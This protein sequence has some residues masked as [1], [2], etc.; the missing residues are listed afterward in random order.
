MRTLGL[1]E[2]TGVELEY[3]IVDQQ[4]LQVRPVADRLLRDVAGT[5]V[6]EVD[7]GDIAWSNE[8]V[9]H[10]IELKTNGPASDLNKLPGLFHEEV[11]EINRLLKK[12][13]AQLMPTAMHPWMDPY[14]EMKLWPHEYNPI[15]EAY[16]RIF[17]CRGHGWANL[18][19]T[20]INLPFAN[21]QEFEKLHAAIRI[22]L[23]ILPALAASS[24]VADNSVQQ[25][26]DYRLEVY[27]TN[28][29][30][31][32]SVTGYVI[33]EAVFS[34]GDYDAEILQRMYRDIAPH[35]PEGI[36]QEEWLNSRGAIARFDRGSIEI[37][38][39]DIQECPLA[40][41]GIVRIIVDALTALSRERWS[42]LEDQKSWNEKELYKILLGTVKHAENSVIDNSRFLN[43]FGLKDAKI[44]AGQLWKHIYEEL[45]G[46]S[47]QQEPA[48][49]MLGR[50]LEAGTLSKRI[51]AALANGGSPG[52]IEEIYRS[53]CDCLSTNSIFNAD[54]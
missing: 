6:S 21:D 36:L 3:M 34:R 38:V 26:A 25:F 52:N 27:R 45:Y 54:G 17:D 31:I 46:G 40:D 14:T 11:T 32:P 33:P 30:R 29:K 53:L 24:P 49:E 9:L 37:R 7:R 35:D 41:I 16:N 1:F 20:H 8:L 48:L 47:G 4:T 50:M 43:L 15:Y 12:Y 13:D 5:Q 19:S 23:P 18:Q 51:T 39:L 28:S 44:E 42:S 2:A 22:L 10:V